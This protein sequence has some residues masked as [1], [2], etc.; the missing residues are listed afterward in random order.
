MGAAGSNDM[1][2]PIGRCCCNERSERDEKNFAP[3]SNALPRN[4]RVS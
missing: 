3:G 1:D 4:A 2:D